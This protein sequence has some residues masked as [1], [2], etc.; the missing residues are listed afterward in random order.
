MVSLGPHEAHE[1]RKQ[2]LRC[3]QHGHMGTD[4]ALQGATMLGQT[5]WGQSCQCTAF[6]ILMLLDFSE[7]QLDGDGGMGRSPLSN[8]KDPQL[9]SQE[10][11]GT[12]F[13]LYLN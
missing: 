4:K 6:S 5:Q 3:V 2:G 13:I 8:R 10:K 11:T 7:G 9:K 1:G 12:E